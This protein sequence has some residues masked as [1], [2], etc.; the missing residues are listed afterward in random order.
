[1]SEE[2]Y[3]ALAIRSQAF[4]RVE[5]VDVPQ[6]GTL[7]NIAQKIG[8]SIIAR[9]PA[10]FT[11][12]TY[13]KNKNVCFSMWVNDLGVFEDKPN[14]I[15][16]HIAES[17][18]TARVER[19]IDISKKDPKNADLERLYEMAQTVKNELS[20]VHGDAVITLTYEEGDESVGVDF[21]P[22]AYEIIISMINAETWEKLRDWSI[23]L[24][25]VLD[26]EQEAID[27]E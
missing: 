5:L 7:S 8:C 16:T 9:F 14:R 11:E 21:P 6:R 2:T 10:K 23:R 24:T 13:S 20:P 3:K 27:S 25:E 12:N 19:E 4:K 26:A 18:L 22:Q 1:M 15:A 17:L